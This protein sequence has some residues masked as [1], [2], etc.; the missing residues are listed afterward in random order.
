MAPPPDSE[1][2]PAPAWLRAR[3]LL[4]QGLTSWRRSIRTRVVVSVLVLGALVAGSVGW[5]LMRQISDGVIQGR[6]RPPSPT[7]WSETEHRP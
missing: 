6:V 2:T 1:G 3:R 5:L 7:G 4:G